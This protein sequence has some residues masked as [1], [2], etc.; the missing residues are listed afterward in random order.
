MHMKEF[1]DDQITENRGKCLFRRFLL[2]SNGA[3]TK[4]SSAITEL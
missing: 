4:D 3:H 1:L 2:Q